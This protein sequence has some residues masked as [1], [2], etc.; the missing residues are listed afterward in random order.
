MHLW[1]AYLAGLLTLPV[2]LALGIMLGWWLRET[3]LDAAN[4]RR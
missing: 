4:R 2:L 3:P 1:E